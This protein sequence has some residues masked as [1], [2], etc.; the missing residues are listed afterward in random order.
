MGSCHACGQAIET[1]EKIR[2]T[3]EC[4]QCGRDVRCCRNCRHFDPGLHNQCREVVAEWVSDKERANFC[5]YFVLADSKGT[6]PRGD[7]KS[8]EDLAREKFRKLFKS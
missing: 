7:G 2:R 5:D 6:H 3:D 4:P 8:P 1:V